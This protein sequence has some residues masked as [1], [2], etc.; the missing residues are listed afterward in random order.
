MGRYEGSFEKWIANGRYEGAVALT[1][2]NNENVGKADIVV[3]VSMVRPNGTNMVHSQFSPRGGPPSTHHHLNITNQKVNV[4]YSA[5]AIP[6]SESINAV[7]NEGEEESKQTTLLPDSVSL[8]MP[9]ISEGENVLH[10][11]SLTAVEEE[12]KKPTKKRKIR[13]NNGKIAAEPPPR[14]ENTTDTTTGT[15]TNVI[16]AENDQNNKGNEIFTDADRERIF[17]GVGSE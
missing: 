17:H 14:M 12:N 16:P 4:F 9:N 3:K 8:S 1:D 6:N 7:H 5:S 11:T 13:R 10:E 2:Q 15:C